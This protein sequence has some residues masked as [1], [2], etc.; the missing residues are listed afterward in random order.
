MSTEDREDDPLLEIALAVADGNQLSWELLRQQV[1]A[2]DAAVLDA[3]RGVRSLVSSRPTADPRLTAP[4]RWGH[5]TVLGV[6]GPGASPRYFARDENAGRE[7]LLTLIGPL[8]GDAHRTNELLQRARR[9]ASISHP[10]LASVYGADYSQDRVGFWAERL[11][12]RSLEDI[13]AAGTTYGVIEACHIVAALC[14]AVAAL[15]DADLANGG[16]SPGDIFE[17]PRGPVLQASLSTEPHSARGRAIERD[18]FDLGALLVLLLS[19]NMIREPVDPAAVVDRLKGRRP[20]V[21][22]SVLSVIGRGLSPDV[23]QRYG[24]ARQLEAAISDAT[25]ESPLTTEWVIGFSVTAAAV[26]V[27]LAYALLVQ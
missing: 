9:R 22:P 20:D 27:L 7:V 26:T 4:H 17:T 12:G 6:A 10:N 24:T 23:H 1:S 11:T 15:H 25:R 18:L 8:D 2:E 13:V 3:L 14:G 5:L 16:I 21:A 19:G